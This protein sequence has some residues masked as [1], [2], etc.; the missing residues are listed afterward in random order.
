MEREKQKNIQAR[1]ILNVVKIDGCEEI[2]RK[3]AAYRKNR[4]NKK[5]KYNII[6]Q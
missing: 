4:N 3:F 6:V 1:F 2:K 5:T